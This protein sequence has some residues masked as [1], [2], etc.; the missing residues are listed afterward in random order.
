LADFVVLLEKG[1]ANKLEEVNARRAVPVH[2]RVY[3]TYAQLQTLPGAAKM[4][5][6]LIVLLIC[7][8]GTASTGTLVDPAKSI[9]FTTSDP[10]TDANASWLENRDTPTVRLIG[11]LD[12]HEVLAVNRTVYQKQL[13][14]TATENEY[15]YSG[16]V[17]LARASNK[18]AGFNK[19]GGGRNQRAARQPLC[20][21]TRENY[22][23]TPVQGWILTR[24]NVYRNPMCKPVAR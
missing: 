15:A 16:L 20:A 7:A 22:S 1:N 21:P 13:E 14:D 12:G 24:G 9:T 18:M 23:Y 8:G 2:R 10:N 11:Y 4:T 19:Y 6:L 17:K 5:M 3:F